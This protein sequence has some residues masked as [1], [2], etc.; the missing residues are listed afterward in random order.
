MRK[1][2]VHA[3]LAGLV[4]LNASPTKRSHVSDRR[5]ASQGLRNARA[6]RFLPEINRFAATPDEH[7]ESLSAL[8]ALLQPGDDTVYLLQVPPIVVPPGLE[9]LRTAS[10]VQMVAT[11][12]LRVDDGASMLGDADAA[13]MLALATLAEPGPLFARTHTMGRFIGL[14][15]DG[16]LVA[17]AGERMRVPGHVEVSGVCTHPDCRGRGFARRLSA[18]VTAEIQRRG[19]QPFL[20]AWTTNTAAIALYANLGFE[21]RAPVNVAVLRRRPA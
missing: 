21:L 17:M 8:T 18:A 10:G 5:G 20:H 11:R 16:R 13:E 1:G 12:R 6:R 7:A 3:I 19:E 15:V 14:R 4:L 2:S 9:V